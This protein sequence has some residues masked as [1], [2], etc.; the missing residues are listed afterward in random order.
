MWC[1]TFGPLPLSLMR[2][3][4]VMS[5]FD[6]RVGASGLQCMTVNGVSRQM[7]CIG[8]VFADAQIVLGVEPVQ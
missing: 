7:A 1:K 8:F 3:D 5:D 6:Q 4:Q 2:C